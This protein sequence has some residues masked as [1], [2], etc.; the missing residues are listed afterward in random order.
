MILLTCKKFV[1]FYEDIFMV[2]PNLSKLLSNIIL[3]C[4][5]NENGALVKEEEIEHMYFI[6]FVRLFHL[7]WT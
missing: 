6:N 4:R 3:L 5:E 7:Q 2:L 1:S